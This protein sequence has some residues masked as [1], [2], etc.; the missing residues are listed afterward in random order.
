[1]PVCWSC[2]TR[3]N[4][5][6]ITHGTCLYPL[7]RWTRIT[8][9]EQGVLLYFSNDMCSVCKVLKPKVSDLLKDSFPAC[10]V[11]MW[12]RIKVPC[13]QDNT[14]CFPFPP[15]FC[16]LKARNRARFSRNISL[17]QLEEAISRPYSMIFGDRKPVQVINNAGHSTSCGSVTF[18]SGV[19][20][21]SL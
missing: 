8:G 18:R 14:G 1:M 10:A 20:S 12:T 2:S 4:F 13:W 3:E 5:K 9:T 6:S 21:I 16:F 15:S 11:S 7:N 19:R 17:Y